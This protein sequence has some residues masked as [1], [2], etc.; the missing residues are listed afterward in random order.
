MQGSR[1]VKKTVIKLEKMLKSDFKKEIS[2]EWMSDN[3][4][5]ILSTC[6]SLTQGDY[7]G[8]TQRVLELAKQLVEQGEGIIDSDTVLLTKRFKLSLNEY[9]FLESSIKINLLWLIHRCITEK[10]AF[11]KYAP[12]AVKSLLFTSV[13]YGELFKCCVESEAILSE[14]CVFSNSDERTRAQYREKITELCKKSKYTEAQISSLAVQNNLT[15][16]IFGEKSEQ[17]A[18]TLGIKAGHAPINT[19]LMLYALVAFVSL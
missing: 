2:N 9:G 11:E 13:D 19:R 15:E 5:K 17:F 16:S 10:A 4:N 14:D 8:I 6:H 7:R 3:K 1:S 12:N 18:R